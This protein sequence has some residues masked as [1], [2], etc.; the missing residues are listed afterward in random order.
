[1]VDLLTDA[2][3]LAATEPAEATG[4][5]GSFKARTIDEMI[6]AVRFARSQVAVEAASGNGWAML[7]RARAVPPGTV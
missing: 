2:I 6:A 4:D 5:A 1:M 7:G 3:V